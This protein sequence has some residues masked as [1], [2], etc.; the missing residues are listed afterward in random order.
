M[1]KVRDIETLI[2]NSPLFGINLLP[3]RFGVKTII[4]EQ[5]NNHPDEKIPK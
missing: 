1:K 2:D 5:E 4:Q 3:E